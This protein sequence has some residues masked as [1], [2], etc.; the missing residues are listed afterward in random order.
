MK[1]RNKIKGEHNF[2]HHVNAFLAVEKSFVCIDKTFVFAPRSLV[3]LYT[4]FP[5]MRGHH[6]AESR[7]SAGGIWG[8]RPAPK[9][10]LRGKMPQETAAWRPVRRERFP[11]LQAASKIF[12]QIFTLTPCKW[13]KIAV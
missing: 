6:T 5:V 11:A 8:V 10:A 1:D 4:S 12:H 9:A 7:F 3:H 13:R 2:F